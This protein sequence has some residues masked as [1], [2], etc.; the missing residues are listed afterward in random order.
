LLAQQDLP[1]DELAAATALLRQLDFHAEELRLIDTDLRQVAWGRPEVPRRL[2]TVP[3]I[4]ATVALS[5]VAAVGDFT[6]F[7]PGSSWSPTSGSNPR[8]RQF[9]GQPASYG[10]MTQAGSAQARGMLSE[11]AWPGIQGPRTAAR[12]LPARRDPLQRGAAFWHPGTGSQPGCG[13]GTSTPP[14]QSGPIVDTSKS[15]P[16]PPP[17]EQRP[18]A[19]PKAHPTEGNSSLTFVRGAAAR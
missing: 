14:L 16:H 18:Q 7:R 9:G 12:V 2:M 8:A 10:R 4:H 19:H 6:R 11:A 5:I 17:D 13:A 1:P 15:V 3:G